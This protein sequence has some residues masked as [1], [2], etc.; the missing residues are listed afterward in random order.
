MPAVEICMTIKTQPVNG[1]VYQELD[2]HGNQHV[3]DL[4]GFEK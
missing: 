2:S 3:V 4:M 1:E